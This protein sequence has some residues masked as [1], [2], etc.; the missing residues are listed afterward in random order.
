MDCED[1]LLQYQCPGLH[2]FHLGASSP[3]PSCPLP[4]S[5][6]PTFS[7]LLSPCMAPLPVATHLSSL[8]L[9]LTPL[10][11]PSLFPSGSAGYFGLAS[12]LRP[13]HSIFSVAWEDILFLLLWQLSVG[14]AS[15]TDFCD[16]CCGRHRCIL[17]LQLLPETVRSSAR[18][19][20]T[21]A[22]FFIPLFVELR[23]E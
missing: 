18:H 16:V 1:K 3:S 14:D 11:W 5:P 12:P 19:Q 10:P 21:C 17:S 7:C 15:D 23:G 4:P 9:F 8:S 13:L 2:P 6:T 20:G 22:L